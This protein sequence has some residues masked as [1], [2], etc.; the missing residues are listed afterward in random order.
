MISSSPARP[1]TP[2][3]AGGSS[4]TIRAA[5]STCP[6][7]QNFQSFPRRS[8]VLKDD[9]I[10]FERVDLTRLKAFD[11]KLDATNK[12]TELLL[13]IGR[14]SLASGSTI[15]LGGHSSRLDATDRHRTRQLGTA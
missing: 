9:L 10:D 13:V 4:R 1:A 15:G 6:T 5:I 3:A 8:R 11:R 7:L 2:P 12:L 14:D